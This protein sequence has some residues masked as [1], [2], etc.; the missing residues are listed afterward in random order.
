MDWTVTA[1]A[2]WYCTMVDSRIGG[3]LQ[4]LDSDD[5]TGVLRP[6]GTHALGSSTRSLSAMLLP[7][8]GDDAHPGVVHHGGVCAV[9]ADERAGDDR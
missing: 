9:V 8:A 5:E 7:G 2:D 3:W 6:A 4:P 1:E